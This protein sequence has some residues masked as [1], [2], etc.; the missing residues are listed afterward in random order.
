[1]NLRTT[2]LGLA[3]ALALPLAGCLGASQPAP[4]DAAVAQAV[5]R[6]L[7]TANAAPPSAGA[8]ASALAVTGVKNLGCNPAPDYK[9]FLCET[10]ID[11]Q[12]RT[13]GARQQQR[14]VRMLKTAGGWQ[15]TMQ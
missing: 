15:A 4:S 7:L 5:T 6:L 3:I 8:T 10:L 9:G 2:R 11:T 14:L 12:S 13:H 1:M